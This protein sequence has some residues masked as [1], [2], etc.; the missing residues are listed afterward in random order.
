MQHYRAEDLWQPNL[1]PRENGDLAQPLPRLRPEI[2]AVHTHAVAEVARETDIV[3]AASAT[4]PQTDFVAEHGDPR[5]NLLTRQGREHMREELG[6]NIQMAMRRYTLLQSLTEC[7]QGT[8]TAPLLG[9][10]SMYLMGKEITE[11]SQLFSIQTT[12]TFDLHDTRTTNL[13]F[14]HSGILT[15]S[16]LTDWVRHIC[17]RAVQS[18]APVETVDHIGA[19]PLT[20]LDVVAHAKTTA[21]YLVLVPTL[22]REEF[23]RANLP[24]LCLPEISLIY[25]LYN[26]VAD[27]I[28]DFRTLRTTRVEF[29]D[30]VRYITTATL[31]LTYRDNANIR[32][33]NCVIP[34][35]S[36]AV[37]AELVR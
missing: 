28:V 26:P 36:E 11:S 8:S 35:S 34:V 1:V 31:A 22:A 24:V 33:Y 5:L 23:M 16:V 6:I 32:A 15:Q 2:E 4:L 3:T 17:Q 7:A 18:I 25:C 30:R 19:D 37:I 12:T 21:P 13:Q 27:L 9:T 14:D 29:H 10:A 20:I